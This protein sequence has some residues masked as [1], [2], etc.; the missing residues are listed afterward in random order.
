[1]DNSQLA[2][3]QTVPQHF[4]TLT[5]CEL[6][7]CKRLE[8]RIEMDVPLMEF[9]LLDLERELYARGLDTT[10]TKQDRYDRLFAASQAVNE[11]PSR[12]RGAILAKLGARVQL[13]NFAELRLFVESEFDIFSGKL[14]WR[15]EHVRRTEDD[16]GLEYFHANVLSCIDPSKTYMLNIDELLVRQEPYVHKVRNRRYIEGYT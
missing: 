14:Q 6:F 9:N 5:L 2:N 3:S 11:V 13:E 16:L 4:T 1:M 7:V 10:G 12:K 15:L 8:K